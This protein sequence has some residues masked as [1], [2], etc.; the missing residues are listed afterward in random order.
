ME[1]AKGEEKAIE[2]AD[3]KASRIFQGAENV[4]EHEM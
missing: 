3:E 1:W 4:D 2:L